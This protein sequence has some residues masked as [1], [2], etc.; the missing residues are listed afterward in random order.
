MWDGTDHEGRWIQGVWAILLAVFAILGSY[1]VLTHL[2]FFLIVGGVP[3]IIGATR[4]SYRCAYY[5]LTGEK[6]INRDDY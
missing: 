4:I 2:G 1:V 5:A 6:N 3:V